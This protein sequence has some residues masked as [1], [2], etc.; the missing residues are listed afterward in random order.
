MI[1][2]LYQQEEDLREKEV[3]KNVHHNVDQEESFR[4]N[5]SK[6]ASRVRMSTQNHLSVDN[7]AIEVSSDNDGDIV[8]ALEPTP[9]YFDKHNADELLLIPDTRYLT[10]KLTNGSIIVII[11]SQDISRVRYAYN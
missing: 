5:N 10:D 9:D 8:L 2:T 4:K 11:S 6:S 7:G 1:N 3:L